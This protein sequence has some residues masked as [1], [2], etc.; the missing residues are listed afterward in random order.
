MIKFTSIVVIPTYFYQIKV[1]NIL[2][3]LTSLWWNIV[4]DDWNTNISSLSKWQNLE[5]CKSILPKL[6][7]KE[8]QIMVGLQLVLLTIY[9]QFRIR[10][11]QGKI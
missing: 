11:E 3:I 7:Y 6:T 5:V 1:W 10:I 4:M 9:G 8:C 2:H